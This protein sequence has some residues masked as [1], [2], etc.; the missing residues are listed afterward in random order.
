MDGEVRR[1]WMLRLRII[2]SVVM[3]VVLFQRVHLS[4]VFP[5]WTMKQFWLLCAG[6]VV[7]GVGIVLSAM[8]WQAVL[9]ALDLHARLRTLLNHYLASLFVGNFL[10]S[11]IGGDVL[12][13]SRLSA[14]NHESPKTFASVV[15]ER[16]TG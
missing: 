9:A 11:T 16:L 7:T 15:L 2:A 12:R 6:L 14:E 10:P 3:L 8:R 1:R 5:E 13:V 4:S